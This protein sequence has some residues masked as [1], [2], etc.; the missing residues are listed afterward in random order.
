MAQSRTDIAFP[1]FDSGAP[2]DAGPDALFDL[3]AGID[4]LAAPPDLS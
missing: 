3:G 2:L 1:I 4:L